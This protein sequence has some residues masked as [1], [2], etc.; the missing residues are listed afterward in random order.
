MPA[1]CDDER[2]ATAFHEAGHIVILCLFGNPAA[3]ATISPDGPVRGQVESDEEVPPCV[4]RFLDQS[5][6][7]RRYVNRYLI[8]TVAGSVAHDLMCPGRP[9]D[10]GDEND[11]AH[12]K[13]YIGLRASWADDP[14]GYL[15]SILMTAR[16]I[17]EPRRAVLQAVADALVEH[18]ELTRA[19]MAA[20]CPPDP[21]AAA[22]ADEG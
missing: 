7:K 15:A 6:E 16:R 4:T 1:T 13:D 12:G 19:Q 3:R 5:A 21:T 17:L 14:D 11:L 22:L 10:G 8:L 18:D 20:M 9:H 2:G